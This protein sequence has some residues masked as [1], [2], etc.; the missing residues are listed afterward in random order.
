M[1]EGSTE[2]KLQRWWG[3]DSASRGQERRAGQVEG[4]TW[5][6][7]ALMPPIVGKAD[8]QIQTLEREVTKQ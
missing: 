7:L 5:P 2:I 8:L 4:G 3:T 1:G 6:T